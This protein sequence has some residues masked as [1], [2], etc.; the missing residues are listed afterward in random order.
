[1]GRYS[2]PVPKARQS[3]LLGI[4]GILAFLAVFFLTGMLFGFARN[5]MAPNF[6][7]VLRH[8]WTYAIIAVISEYLRFRLI[9]EAADKERNL[10]AVAVTLVFALAQLDVLRGVMDAGYVRNV[11]TLFAAVLPVLALNGVLTFMAHESSLRALIMIRAAYSL[12]PVL[13]PIIPNVPRA[14]WAVITGCLLLATVIFYHKNIS[15]SNKRQQRVEK[16]Q[17]KHEKKSI[18]AVVLP[19]AALVFLIAFSLRLFAYFPVVIL[20]G[21]MTGAVDRGSIVFVEK[22][23]PDDVFDTVRDGEIILFR[24][25]RVEIMHR[26]IEF[27]NNHLGER[28]YITKGDN[29][30]SADS[31]PVEMEQ[32]LGVSRAYIPHIGW[33]FVIIDAILNNP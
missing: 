30:A 25:G 7:V 29:N 17:G 28:V 26:V 20:T 10:I 32:V 11:E 13:S 21:S 27:G 2:R 16:W 5:G 1:M 14:A 12:T 33:P 9:K 24:R 15:E 22:V 8:V 6:T 23:R 4:L 31:A 18:V 19:A 3:F